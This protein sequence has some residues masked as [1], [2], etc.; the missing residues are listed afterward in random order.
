MTRL[1]GPV[2]D[3]ATFAASLRNRG[4]TVTPDQVSD[5]ARAISMETENADLYASRARIHLRH[6]H[7]DR[8]RPDL[9]RA[10]ELEP[11]NDEYRA[12]LEK[13]GT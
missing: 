3:L 2:R 10:L 5:M 1:A 11:A 7:P 13:L 8:A 6:Q 9:V 12:M 4:L